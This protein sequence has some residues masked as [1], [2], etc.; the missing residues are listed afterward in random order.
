MVKANLSSF[1]VWAEL[2]GGSQSL[3]NLAL[4]ALMCSSPM[5]RNGLQPDV[6]STY[7]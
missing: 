6:L 7:F 5:H 3:H 4:K 1:K 2:S